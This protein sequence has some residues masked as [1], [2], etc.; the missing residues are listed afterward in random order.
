[1]GG[2]LCQQRWYALTAPIQNEQVQ[3]T[4]KRKKR[5]NEESTGNV[6]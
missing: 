1:M 3:E 6:R 2:L 4:E 5:I